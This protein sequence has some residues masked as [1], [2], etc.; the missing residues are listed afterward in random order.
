VFD[1]KFLWFSKVNASFSHRYTHYRREYLL[2][3]GDVA[4]SLNV[5]CAAPSRKPNVPAEGANTLTL[6]H[7]WTFQDEVG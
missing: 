5:P 7:L 1:D 4:I 6:L 3:G 2:F